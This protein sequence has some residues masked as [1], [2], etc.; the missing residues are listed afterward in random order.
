ML[1]TPK[2]VTEYLKKKTTIKNNL[3]FTEWGF[4]ARHE[5]PF[6]FF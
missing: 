1:T 6:L 3:Q 5:F 4:D 2:N